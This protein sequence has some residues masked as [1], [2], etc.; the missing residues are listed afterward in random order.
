MQWNLIA[1]FNAEIVSS[2]RILYRTEFDTWC[3]I[4]M[5]QHETVI[6]DLVLSSI[7]TTVTMATLYNMSNN[8]VLN[9]GF[10]QNYQAFIF[11]VIAPVWT[12]YQADAYKKI[13][14]G[15]HNGLL[16]YPEE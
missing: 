10:A 2:F 13:T 16:M 7:H 3:T 4:S 5:K 12:P 1:L 6:Y 8:Y 14:V 9:V 11:S 15:G